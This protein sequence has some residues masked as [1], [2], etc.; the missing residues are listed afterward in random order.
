MNGFAVSDY[1]EGSVAMTDFQRHLS[2]FS[3]LEIFHLPA[4]RIVPFDKSHSVLGNPRL[5]LHIGLRIVGTAFVS[6]P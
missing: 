2:C 3:Q 1:Y 6:L 4:L 5:V